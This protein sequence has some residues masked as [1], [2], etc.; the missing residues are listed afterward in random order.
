MN[1]QLTDCR[2]TLIESKSSLLQVSEY[3][4][5][6]YME[7]RSNAQNAK[8]CLEQTKK[9]TTQSLASV[10]YQMN[11]LAT[12]FLQ[13]LEM[14]TAQLSQ[15]ETTISQVGQKV[16]LYQEKVARREIGKLANKKVIK[17]DEA[18][19]KVDPSES[20]PELES[21]P[22]RYIRRGI[23][24]HA[25][26]NVGCGGVSQVWNQNPTNHNTVSRTY[27][28]KQ[29]LNQNSYSSDH[30]GHKSNQSAISTGSGNNSNIAQ[31]YGT[32]ENM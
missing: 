7:N 21:R 29:G 14:Q 28:N 31:S 17:R 16:D 15:L 11:A 6:N 23:D 9:F 22:H 12:T 5:K 32:L 3:C 13:I 30:G 20:R 25:L 1:K 27:F 18:V 24:I 8:N 10:A 4:D 2:A 19:R 26:D